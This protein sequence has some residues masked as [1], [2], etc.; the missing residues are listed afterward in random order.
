MSRLSDRLA[1]V[2][3]GGGGDVIVLREDFSVLKKDI[4][5]QPTEDIAPPSPPVAQLVGEGSLEVIGESPN[6]EEEVE[7]DEDIHMEQDT[8]ILATM[9][10]SQM[11]TSMVETG[12]TTLDPAGMVETEGTPPLIATP[13]PVVLPP[14]L[15][16]PTDPTYMQLD[17]TTRNQPQQST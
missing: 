5:E 9:E 8:V 2:E 7:I 13:S 11:D 15:E 1:R 3:A 12:D 16:H 10:R 6:D 17:T 4:D 14:S